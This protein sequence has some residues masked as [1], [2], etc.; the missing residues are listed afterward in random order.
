MKKKE[1]K[2][3]NLIELKRMMKV[4]IENYFSKLIFK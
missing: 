2:N 1:K 4:D 3:V